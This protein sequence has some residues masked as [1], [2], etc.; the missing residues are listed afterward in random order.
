MVTPILVYLGVQRLPA[1]AGGSRLYLAYISPISPL[2]LAHISPALAGGSL[3]GLAVP[4][5]TDI[6]FAMVSP[7]P[8]PQH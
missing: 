6:A 8:S 3:A 5:A 4:M 7:S 1:L 2:H